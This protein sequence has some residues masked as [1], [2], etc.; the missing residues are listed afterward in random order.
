[1]DSYKE[2]LKA[3][4]RPYRKAVLKALL[5]L[6][7]LGGILFAI[8]NLLTGSYPLAIVE[9]AMGAY[10]ILVFWA[11]RDTRHLERWII[12][13]AIPFFT[14]MMFA[15]TIPKASATVHAWVL[16]IPIVSHLLMGR[17][18]GLAIS[19]FYMSI[20]GVIFLLRYHDEP[21]MMQALPVANIAVISLCILVFSH[22]YEVTRE[23]SQRQL[24]KIA[25][26][27][28]L[29]GLANRARLSDI[30]KRE[31]QR[32]RRYNTPM[33]LLALDLDH[34]KE[35]NDRYGHDTGDLALQHVARIF[36]EC[37]RATDLA[38]RLGGE[39]FGIL[40]TN[41]NGQQGLEVAEKIRIA[42]ASTPLTVNND[43][44]RLTLSGG[45]AEFGPDGETLRQLV[46][47]ADK[48]LYEAKNRGRNLII[49]A[50]ATD[51]FQEPLE[52]DTHRA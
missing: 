45:V 47:E 52:T 25:Q 14:A 10:A 5:V 49:P 44:V 11:V 1:M 26:T 15:M 8:L 50:E 33:T 51:G 17:R 41:T 22:V 6:T 43:V 40:L 32:S 24:L 3:L 48:R 36:R 4:A 12:A 16:L 19:V 7:M 27:D 37:L 21:A 46:R 31:Q 20:A 23:Q 2:P 28:T 30:F 42:V 35:V 39:E 13:Y 38:A 18:L 34:F 29:T 9:L